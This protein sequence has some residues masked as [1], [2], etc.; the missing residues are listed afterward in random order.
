M[1]RQVQREY[2]GDTFLA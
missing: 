2:S 1:T